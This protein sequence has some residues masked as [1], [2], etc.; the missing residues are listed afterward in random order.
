MAPSP[1]PSPGRLLV[2]APALEDPNFRRAVVLLLEHNDE[3]SL[4]VV[5]NRPSTTPLSDPLPAWAAWVSQPAHVFIGGPVQQDGALGLGWRPDG[6]PGSGLRVLD[7]AVGTVDL[8]EDPASLR[9]AASRVF[10]GYAG[11]GAGQLD[12]ELAAGAWYV[13]DAVPAD[14]FSTDPENLWSTVLR[15]QGGELAF[16]S[17]FPE[18][19]ALN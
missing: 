10:A 7:H 8:D 16:V 5:V 17:L 18:D 12:S 2:A 1:A 9:L 14:A 19:P 11:W 6:L 13:V 3:G 15:R 4:G